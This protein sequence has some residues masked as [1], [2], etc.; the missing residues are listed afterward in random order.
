MLVGRRAHVVATS[1]VITLGSSNCDLLDRSTPHRRLD[2][3]TDVMSEVAEDT[4]VATADIRPFR[5]SFS[6]EQLDDLRKRVE[7]TRWPERE[8]VADASQGVQLAT[9]QKLAQYWATEHDWRKCEARL[10]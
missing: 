7:A 4:G 3:M 1:V 9:A 5:V 2:A 10:N 8:T 6:D